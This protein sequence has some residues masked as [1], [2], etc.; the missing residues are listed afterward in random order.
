[1]KGMPP[2]TDNFRARFLPIRAGP[3]WST[4]NEDVDTMYY[5]DLGP[6]GAADPIPEQLC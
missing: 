3:L 6:A 4:E 2:K 5:K 1:M